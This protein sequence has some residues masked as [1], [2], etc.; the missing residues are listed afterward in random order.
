MPF[1]SSAFSS[2]D[3]EFISA[4]TVETPI[5]SSPELDAQIGCE[6][7]VKDETIQRGG[8]FKFRG[9]IL[10]VRNASRGVVAAGAGNFPIAVGL[11]AQALAKPACLIVPPDAP[12]FKLERARLTGATV[13]LTDRS[14]LLD[15]ALS[16]AE[17]R[18]WSNLHAFENVEMI[19]GSY[20]LGL[21]IAAAIK[22]SGP[23]FNAV[24]V[25]CGGGGLAAGLALALRARSIDAEIY[26]A[27]PETHQ[28]YA[29]ARA[30]VAPQH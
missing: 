5:R 9:A 6:V 14:R 4:H 2:S 16:E 17:A 20:T 23:A 18:R 1:Q 26:L 24:I 25:A 8:S 12:A 27:E 7:R 30:R 11:A 13:K 10:A 3:L 19:A 15:C 22:D 28:R 29:R 21:E